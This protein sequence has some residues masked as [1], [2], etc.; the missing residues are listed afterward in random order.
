MSAGPHDKESK[1]I[2][3]DLGLESRTFP[4]PQGLARVESRSAGG[5]Q[6]AA[7]GL[8]QHRHELS[9][10]L[11]EGFR[12]T[13]KAPP[14]HPARL[15]APDVV[16]GPRPA[17]SRHE[18]PPGRTGRPVGSARHGQSPP[19]VEELR[20]MCFMHLTTG[21]DSF[22]GIASEE[23]LISA[24]LMMPNLRAKPTN[25][26]LQRMEQRRSHRVA[27]RGQKWSLALL[28]PFPSSQQV[29]KSPCS[30]SGSLRP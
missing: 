11:T 12:T 17:G 27:P 19:A 28:P 25:S 3:D 26:A 15:A 16:V 9:T 2:W 5:I 13:Q 8:L 24:M 4:L 1:R 22:W 18:L 6:E 21:G 30:N 10:L 14:L 23:S 29:S 20:S 7:H